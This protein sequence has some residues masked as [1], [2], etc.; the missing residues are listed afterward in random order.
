MQSP[1]RLSWQFLDAAKHTKADTGMFSLHQLLG[2]LRPNGNCYDEATFLLMQLYPQAAGRKDK[3]GH[4]P[5]HYALSYGEVSYEVVAA[6]LHIYPEAA[7]MPS[8]YVNVVMRMDLLLLF[9]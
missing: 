5:L 6:L 7:L 1:D 2:F 8:T 3:Y 9:L 4:L